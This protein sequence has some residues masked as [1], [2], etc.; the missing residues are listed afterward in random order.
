MA[1]LLIVDD[2][3]VIRENLKALFED[4]GYEV[5]LAA[6]GVKAVEKFV[7]EKPDLI[8]MDVMMPRMSGFAAIKKIREIDERTPVVFLTAKDSDADEMHALALGAHDF[9]S[10]S[11]ECGVLLLRVRR[12]LERTVEIVS[13]KCED[14]VLGNVR[15]DSVSFAVTVNGREKAR[16]TKTEFDF[17]KVLYL[18][19]DKYIGGD[20]LLQAL[21]GEG[22]V[23]EDSMLYVHASNLR[24]KLSS[25]GARIE[26]TRSLGYRLFMKGSRGK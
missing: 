20:E 6:N 3:R 25:S 16:L 21:R 9:I 14:I 17:L 23:C 4:E 7:D 24:K 19:R 10:K 5:V 22:Y 15:I 11:D 1:K 8:L 2:E 18:N 26:N 13:A 12:A